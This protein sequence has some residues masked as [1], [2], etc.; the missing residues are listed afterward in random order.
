MYSK[1]IEKALEECADIRIM[2]PKTVEIHEEK[3]L[4]LCNINNDKF[5]AFGNECLEFEGTD[6]NLKLVIPIVRGEITDYICTAN[7]FSWMYRKYVKK[8]F[9][10]IKKSVLLCVDEPVSTINI[11]AYEDAV[12]MAGKGD[13]KDIQFV[14]GSITIKPEE[15]TWEQ[16]IE[17]LLE[18]RKDTGCVIH[19]TK[20]EPAGYARSLYREY[21]D[22]CKRWK[23]IPEE[24]TL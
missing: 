1:V 2:D 23:V 24:I 21:L 20:N 17:V 18:R 22:S 14:G 6:P 7:L 4:V 11:K 15:T 10:F 8:G 16:C 13:F 12:M 3:G 5:V 9:I 19:I